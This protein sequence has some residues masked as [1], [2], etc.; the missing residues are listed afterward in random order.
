MKI[1]SELDWYYNISDSELGVAATSFSDSP[2]G[3]S[4]PTPSTRMLRAAAKQ[5][6][7]RRALR[8]L[9][10]QLQ[11]AIEHAYKPGPVATQLRLKYGILAGLLAHRWP[12]KDENELDEV[13]GGAEKLLATAHKAF[14]ICYTPP[15]RTSSWLLNIEK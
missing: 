9:S 2:P 6:S 13:V 5:K 15:D 3:E 10:P 1:V 14:K 12:P 7:V 4:D 8:D 11:S